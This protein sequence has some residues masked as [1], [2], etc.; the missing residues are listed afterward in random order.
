MLTTGLI[1]LR[2]VVLPL[3]N[4]IV[5]FS[6]KFSQVVAIFLVCH[7][8]NSNARFLFTTVC[9]YYITRL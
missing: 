9:Y 7:V 2:Q 3:Y 5:F 4:N 1:Y 8:R 6:F